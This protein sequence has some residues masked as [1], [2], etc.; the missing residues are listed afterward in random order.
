MFLSVPAFQGVPN[1]G[2]IPVWEGVSISSNEAVVFTDAT[3]PE[4]TWTEISEIEYLSFFNAGK[5]SVDKTNIQANGVDTVTVTAIVAPGVENI[6]FY[7]AD[8]GS[9]LGIQAVDD[10]KATLPLTA[11][12]PGVIKVR[13][14]E[15]TK[16]RLN[17]ISIVAT[18][19]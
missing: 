11:T 1:I 6:T 17:E 12:V 19:S 5:I 10:N 18:I 3:N 7:S 4:P 2:Q 9:V 14:G 13:A 16:T 15:Q 8:T